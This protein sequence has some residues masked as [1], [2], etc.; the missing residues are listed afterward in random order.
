MLSRTLPQEAFS[1][2]ILHGCTK[3]VLQGNSMYV[4]TQG[5]EN[6]D[7]PCLPHGLCVANTYTKMTTGNKCVPIVIKNQM[8]ALITI[9]KGIKITWVVAAHRVP[10]VEVMPGT[11]EKLDKIQGIWQTQ[12]IIEQR[13]EMLLQQLDISG[14]EG[15]LG[16]NH[17]SAYALLI[18]YHD[19]FLLEPGELACMSLTK[20]EI[21]VV[22]DE[23]F[24]ERFQRILPPMVKEV[25]AHIKEMLEAGTICPSQSP[26]CNA[27]V[28]VRKK[29]G[30]LHFCID[31]CKLNAWSKKDSYPLPCIEEAIESLVGAGYFSCLDLKAGFW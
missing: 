27:V 13:K 1:S 20:H 2:Q 16:A 19:I 30:G 21:Q 29:D 4:M 10:P 23:P 11:L 3:T 9:G 24:K 22:D 31:F 6:G 14:L 8:A 26:W 28:L 18:K 15:W 7:K 17:M 25:R 5:P 12:M